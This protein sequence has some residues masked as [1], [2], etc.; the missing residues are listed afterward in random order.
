MFA[1]L[2]TLPLLALP[3]ILYNFIALAAIENTTTDVGQSLLSPLA[4]VS[5]FSGDPWNVSGSD[6]LMSFTLLML[7]FEIVKATRTDA[8]SIINHG[9][10]MLVA[11]FCIIEFLTMRGFGNIT[12]GFITISAIL[13]VVAGFTVTIVAA[14]RD[15]GG[16]V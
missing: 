2:N 11:V 5:L 6:V 10:A 8:M 1:I 3:L 7:F 14:K 15:F 13:D 12:F 4:A 9:L 16:S